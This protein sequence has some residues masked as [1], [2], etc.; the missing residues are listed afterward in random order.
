MTQNRENKKSRAGATFALIMVAVIWGSGFIATDLVQ[1]AQWSTHQ[2]MAA[3]F[4]IAALVMLIALRSRIRRARKQEI[5]S[6]L[7]AGV[8]LYLSFYL[9]TQ[10]QGMT[11][12]SNTAFFTATNVVMVPFISWPL[13]KKKPELR[14]VLF[15]LISLIGVAILS[16]SNGSF[17]L[18]SGDLLILLCAFTFASHITF[19]EK[20]GRGTDAGVV[21]FFQ[22]AAAAFISLIVFCFNREPLPAFDFRGGLL[23]VVYLGVFSTCLCYFLQTKA[24]QYVPASVAGVVLSL[25][26]F[27]GSL[28][29]VL[30]GLEKASFSMAAG[31]GLIILAT[32]LMNWDQSRNFPEE[33][34]PETEE[35]GPKSAEHN[36]KNGGGQQ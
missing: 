14:T 1:A 20:A 10:G 32:V 5:A 4:S 12:V 21:N 26:G 3:R 33:L 19:L 9:Q 17:S 25:E 35:P 8:L 16:Y 34:S 7:I 15:T 2:I 11:T 27:F 6:G 29:S 30:M 36:H 13:L 28:F 24:Q 18:N 22:I 31:G 23:P